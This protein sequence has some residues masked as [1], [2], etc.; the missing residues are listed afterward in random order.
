M[1]FANKIKFGEKLGMLGNF[2]ICASS[3]LMRVLQMECSQHAESIV[4][5]VICHAAG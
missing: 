3:Y 5:T 1:S 4:L 2:V